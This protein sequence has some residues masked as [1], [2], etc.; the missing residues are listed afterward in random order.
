MRYVPGNR[1]CIRKCPVGAIYCED[2]L[3]EEPTPHLG[4]NA[5][6]FVDTRRGRD[7]PLGSP[8]GA[9][10]IGALGVG[11]PLVAVLHR[12]EE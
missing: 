4:D 10:T 6:F 12:A 7:A 5:A 3:H 11:T 9:A 8:G 1:A 2:D